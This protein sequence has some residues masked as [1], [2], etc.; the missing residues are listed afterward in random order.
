MDGTTRTAAMHGVAH[1][2]SKLL[3][4]LQILTREVHLQVPYQRELW[5][6]YMPGLGRV[7]P[8]RTQA[9]VDSPSIRVASKD[10]KT[11]STCGPLL[12]QPIRIEEIF[13]E[14]ARVD[15]GLL[16]HAVPKGTATPDGYPEAA[17]KM[18]LAIAPTKWRRKC[19]GI[20]HSIAACPT[21]YCVFMD[22]DLFFFSQP[23]YSW[24]LVGI[25]Y[26]QQNPDALT[27]SPWIMPG[28]TSKSCQC[29]DHGGC[30]CFTAERKDMH[31][32]PVTSTK[33]SDR[34][35]MYEKAKLMRYI[36]GLGELKP[37]SWAMLEH[38]WPSVEATRKAANEPA[39]FFAFMES[40]RAWFVHPPY[41]ESFMKALYGSNCINKL[42]LINTIS[43][44]RYPRGNHCHT[45]YDRCGVMAIEP[46]MPSSL[47]QLYR[48]QQRGEGHRRYDDLSSS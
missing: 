10:S 8:T 13:D 27:V 39:F 35:F 43:A 14:V 29:F 2:G 30:P 11:S 42:R 21:P 4:S 3:Y 7:K 26:L 5:K 25:T 6:A 40:Q 9:I 1:A 28:W 18:A 36:L 19:I 37:E 15:L 22:D 44:G 20:L 17:R 33:F 34:L 23:N 48:A 12:K 38:A 47:P 31:R 41:R 16:E 46:W 32:S 24:P 45:V